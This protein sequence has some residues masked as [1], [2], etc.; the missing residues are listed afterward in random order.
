MRWHDAYLDPASPL[1]LRLRL[2]QQQV[3]HV[4]DHHPPGSI[5]I[6]SICAGQ[7]RDVIDVV[8]THPRSPD[9]HAV[10]VEADPDLVA[11]ARHRAEAAG[12]SERVTVHHGDGSKAAAYIG[13]VP[14]DLVLAC[15]VLGNISDDDTEALIRALPTFCA[16]GA[17]VIWTRHRRPPDKT[18][19]VRALFESAGFSEH[20]FS[21]PDPY[22]LT[23][24][25]H[26]LRIEPAP[27]DPTARLF[28]FV[29][30]G[31]LPA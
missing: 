9:V 11:F 27:F 21:A 3:R 20:S 25:R 8:A 6:T 22:V 26:V 17:S 23:V 19:F 1:S 18:P 16:A 15:G 2:V 13:A 7:G 24:G 14:A 5:R 31:S 28:E 10:L 30:D 12:V 4:L 29:G